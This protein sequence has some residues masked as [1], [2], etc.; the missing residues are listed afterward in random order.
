MEVMRLTTSRRTKTQWANAS[1]DPDNT[2]L[3]PASL[4]GCCPDLLSRRGDA[5]IL[6]LLAR[7]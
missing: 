3:F 1:F 6:K 7:L 4:L 2:K 5:E